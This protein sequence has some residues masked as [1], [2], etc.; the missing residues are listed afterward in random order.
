MTIINNLEELKKLAPRQKF[1]VVEGGR[2]QGY[3]Y[4]G[5]APVAEAQI[6]VAINDSN[7]NKATCFTKS[8]FEYG[9]PVFVTGEYNSEFMGNLKIEQ[10]KKEI[11][12]VEEIYLNKEK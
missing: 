7:W 2:R 1:Y 5:V 11:E 10:L 9:R 6:V 4:M 3:L 8:S 12:I